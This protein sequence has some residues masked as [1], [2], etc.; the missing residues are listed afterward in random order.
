MNER[1]P[2][3][4]EAVLRQ[5]SASSGRVQVNLPPD[6]Y[7]YLD[8]QAR[9]HD[10]SMNYMARKFIKMGAEVWARNAQINNAPRTDGDL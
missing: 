4:D 10:R 2:S 1:P 9:L 3:A 6:D 5:P 8:Q 7:A